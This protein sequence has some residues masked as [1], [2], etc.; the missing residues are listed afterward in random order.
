[1][2]TSR[3][4]LFL[5]RAPGDRLGDLELLLLWRP[6]LPLS[7]SICKDDDDLAGLLRRVSLQASRLAKNIAS[8][9][10][11][12]KKYAAAE[13]AKRVAREGA[14]SKAVGIL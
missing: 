5:E 13:R 10:D 11:I 1:M 14:R 2:R 7:Y 6:A 4:S 3:P 12:E 8:S 9:S